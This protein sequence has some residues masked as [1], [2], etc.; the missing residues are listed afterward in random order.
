MTIFSRQISR[1][2]YFFVVLCCVA[3]TACTVG[4]KYNKPAV[5]V[6]ELYRGTPENAPAS[7]ESIG[8]QKW[9]EVFQD[10]QLQQ[11]I[12]SAL[13]QNYDVRI[14]AAR[15]MQAEAQL[16]LTR[17]NKFPTVNAIGSGSSVRNPAI[18]PIPSYTYN[19]GRVIGSAAWDL[20]FWGKYRRATE[21]ARAQLLASQWSQRE[22]LATLVANVASAYFQLR[23]L[24]LELE[25]SRNAL[26][27]RKESLGLTQTLEEHGINSIL[28]VRQAEQ[29]VYTAS[30]EI[31]DLERRIALQENFLNILLGQNPAAIA[32]GKELTGQ[33]HA[34]VV[35]A[36]LPSSLLQRR[37]DIRQSEQ[38]L[39]AAN[40]EIGV[41]RAAYF[42]DI[43]LTAGPG[44][45]SSA[46]TS[47]FSGSSGL[48]TFAGSITQ[49]IFNGGAIRSNVRLA[50]AQ[51]EQAVLSYQQT[52]QHAFRETSDALIA[53]QKTQE[54]RAQEELLTKSAADAADLSGRRYQAG[55]TN[56]LEVLTNETN[57]FSAQLTLAQSRLN[58]LLALVEIYRA[59]GGGWQQ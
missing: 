43:Q 49:P 29:L 14:A 51:E 32:R 33:P 35:P 59:L 34:P 28:D 16:G 36:G 5:D 25:I 2:I 26:A 45:Q 46:L 17:A 40:A 1:A 12:R 58:E 9:A 38:Q 4:P 37:P 11:L 54:F 57:Y 7:T 31:A 8:D 13:Q 55:T 21:A 24:D 48:W 47:L 39:I 19:S 42:P 20:D 23:E 22:V 44:F 15:V 56:Y 52:V 30:A 27:S 53:Y 18:G 50:Q 10:P 6:P 41:A 3:V